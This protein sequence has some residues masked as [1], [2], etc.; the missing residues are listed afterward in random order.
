MKLSAYKLALLTGATSPFGQE[1][2]FLLAKAS[3]R[4]CLVGRQ[5][6]TLK[7]LQEKLSPFTRVEISPLDLL[8]DVNRAS[9]LTWIHANVPDLVINS[10]GI[11]LYGEALSHPLEEEFDI[12]KLN[13]SVL[14]E[15]TLHSANTLKKNSK[16][17]T[18]VNISSAADRLIY[19]TFSV[20][21]SS[22]AFVSSFSQSL[23]E[24][25][26]PYGIRVLTSCP[27]Q[28]ATHFQKRASKGAFPIP[29]PFAMSC[30]R[31]A[32]EIIYQIEKDKKLHIFP[33]TTYVLRAFLLLFPR[34]LVFYV[35][36]KLIVNRIPHNSL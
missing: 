35:L 5:L 33:K 21:S 20:Y 22:K 1:I 31:A 25:L 24:E 3:V 9:L 36:K 7:N 29:S 30:S 34:S 13:A 2:A 17:G 18:I 10:A 11:G 23:D 8:Q 28:I 12:L 32:K 15:I 26:K 19:P 14:L 16:K 4:L 27:G 6:A